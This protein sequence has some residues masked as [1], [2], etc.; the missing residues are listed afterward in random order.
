M[1]HN[2]LLPTLLVSS[3]LCA[4]A[5]GASAQDHGVYAG[6]GMGQSHNE[7]TYKDRDTAFSLFAGYDF[8]RFI[9]VESGYADLGKLEYLGNVPLEATAPYL[10]AVGKLPL[11]ENVA[12]YAKA[13]IN[14]WSLDDAHPLLTGTGDRSGTDATYGLGVQYRINDRFAVRGDYSRLEVGEMDID[15]A[16]IQAVVRF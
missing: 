10:V 4:M 6:V 16:Q 11:T 5:F 9:G 15:V 13:G 12:V 8:N 2:K 14:H 7:G 3:T 1:R